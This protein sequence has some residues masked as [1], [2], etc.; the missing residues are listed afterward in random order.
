VILN[1][2]PNNLT[3]FICRHLFEKKRPIAYVFANDEDGTVSML[4]EGSDCD[5]VDVA[6]CLLV[7]LGHMRDYEPALEKLT[8]LNSG[9]EAYL[10]KSKD[11]IFTPMA[12]EVNQ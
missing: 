11:W 9:V 2:Q 8:K 6:N 1:V 12:T 4:C 10:T 3:T 7:G 5:P